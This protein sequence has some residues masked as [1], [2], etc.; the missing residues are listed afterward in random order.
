M[1]KAKKTALLIAVILIV[2]GFMISIGA[3]AS[4]RFDSSK[5]IDTEFTTKT[6][7]VEKEFQNI[8]IEADN[9]DI[10]LVPSEDKHCKVV[11]QEEREM[12]CSVCV[13]GDTLVIQQENHRK[14]SEYID[15]SWGK[16]ELTVYLPQTEY[17][18]FKVE[19]L[20]GTIKI[21]KEFTF[22]EASI[23][24]TSGDIYF[25]AAVKGT[26]SL[27]TFSGDLELHNVTAEN[28]E[29]QSISGDIECFRV[30][31]QE[32]LE[33][34]STSGE[35]ELTQSDAAT[36]DLKTVSGDVEG[37]I[38]SGKSFDIDTV[39]GDVM[40]PPSGTGGSCRIETMSGDIE[41]GIWN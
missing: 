3:L 38:L 41:I 10:R 33:I 12:T 4:I 35:I 8:S 11:Y 1:K 32:K 27:E 19:S 26:L 18:E 7:E 14:W 24:N 30:A 2:V 15:F 5:L 6:Y 31:A 37:T 20:S 21:P 25:G 28:I 40:V 13:E 17:R 36:M 34:E 9:Y 23:C 29:M 22:T 39:S 16:R